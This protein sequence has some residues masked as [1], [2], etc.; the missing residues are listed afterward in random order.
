MA[1][2]QRMPLLWGQQ[3]D[4]VK[5][6]SNESANANQGWEGRQEEAGEVAMKTK[7]KVKAGRFSYPGFGTI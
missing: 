4:S 3:R 6:A 1:I 2:A 7:T 5:G